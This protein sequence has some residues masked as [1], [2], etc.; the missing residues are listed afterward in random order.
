MRV[1]VNELIKAVGMKAIH[2]LSV[3]C[4]LAD[5]PPADRRGQARVEPL[6][7]RYPWQHHQL[8]GGEVAGFIDPSHQVGSSAPSSQD[9]CVLTA[10]TVFSANSTSASTTTDGLA[11]AQ[12]AGF[13][14]C[15]PRQAEGCP[16]GHLLPGT[17]GAPR[18]G[19]SIVLQTE[20][21]LWMREA[22]KPLAHPE[23][24]DA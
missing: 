18:P 21:V 22:A 23:A 19:P 13:T 10:Q 2:R 7:W 8:R 9:H 1:P 11:T 4:Y 5:C 6:R 17:P 15:H 3:P 16:L 12:K 20:K 24:G 14:H